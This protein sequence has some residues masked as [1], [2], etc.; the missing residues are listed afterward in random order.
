MLQLFSRNSTFIYN[1]FTLG[2]TNFVRKLGM[3]GGFVGRVAPHK[4][5]N[6]VTPLPVN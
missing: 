1:Y 3:I 4:S 6:C 5:P 2:L